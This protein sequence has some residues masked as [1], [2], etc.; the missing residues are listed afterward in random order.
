LKCSIALTTNLGIASW[1][2]VFN[3]DPMVA[4]AMLDRLLHKS[5]VINIEGDSS[6]MR[7]HR[8][9]AAELGVTDRVSFLHRDAS[10]YIADDP[11]E[12]ASC[13][14]ATWIGGGLVGTVELLRR[15]LGMRG[16][17]LIG[18]PYWRREP[19]DQDAI[20]ACHAS[21]RGQFLPLP[22]LIERFGELGC[23]VVEMVLADQDDWDRYHAAQWLNIRR[24][25]DDNP[26]DELARQVRAEL[27]TAPVLHARYQ[28]EYLGWGVF[29]LMDR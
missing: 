24:W 25:P 12:V 11:V 23:D 3:D 26:N 29:A 22:E 9:R 28:R 2:K 4:A 7:S 1:G 19:P 27:T 10:G 21:A 15:S 16:T 14:G 17:M 6:R 20:E 5:V 8:A 18:E 13:I